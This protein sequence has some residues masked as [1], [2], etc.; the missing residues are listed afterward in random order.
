MRDSKERGW[1][2]SE[3]T[4]FLRHAIAMYPFAIIYHLCVRWY[5]DG[6][7]R[8]ESKPVIGA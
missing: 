8:L 4:P 6:R 2:G 7:G 1:G 5:M 3:P